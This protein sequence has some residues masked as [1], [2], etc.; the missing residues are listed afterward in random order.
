MAKNKGGFRQA[1]PREATMMK[2]V[3]EGV[4][5]GIMEESMEVK[6]KSKA[7]AQAKINRALK[8]PENYGYRVVRRKGGYYG[9]YELRQTFK[10]RSTGTSYKE[11]DIVDLGGGIFGIK[12]REYGYHIMD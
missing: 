12:S 1:P 10:G 2:A 7:D 6:A 3:F 8:Q 4:L 9:D 11:F 5:R